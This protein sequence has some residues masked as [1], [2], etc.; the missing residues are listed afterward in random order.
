MKHSI[1]IPDWVWEWWQQSTGRPKPASA[2]REEIVKITLERRLREE[3]DLLESVENSLLP[4]SI[5]DPDI[6]D[7]NV[8]DD[9]PTVIEVKRIGICRYCRRIIPKGQEALWFTS[10]DRKYLAHAECWEENQEETSP[11]T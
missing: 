4:D 6:I 2:I 9:V 10:H 1:M 3:G 5:N 8:P 11:K 7:F